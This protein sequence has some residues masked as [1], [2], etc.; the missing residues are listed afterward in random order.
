M[1]SLQTLISEG[2]LTNVFKPSTEKLPKFKKMTPKDIKDMLNVFWDVVYDSDR[3]FEYTT[4]AFATSLSKH[5]IDPGLL[6]GDDTILS[7]LTD[8]VYGA[9]TPSEEMLKSAAEA[10]NKIMEKLLVYKWREKIIAILAITIM[11]L[12]IGIVGLLS[13]IM[14]TL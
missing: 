13:Q 10:F 4:D 9:M 14:F 8:I 2:K 5:N 7:A 6:I 12:L 3:I 11:F 1:N